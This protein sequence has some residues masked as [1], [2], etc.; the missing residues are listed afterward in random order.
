MLHGAPPNPTTEVRSVMT[1]IYVADDS[2][3]LAPTSKARSLDL[4]RWLPGLGPGDLVASPI[5]P[6]LYQ[7]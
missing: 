7:R 5:N 2:R 4:E 6:V 3:V 1:V